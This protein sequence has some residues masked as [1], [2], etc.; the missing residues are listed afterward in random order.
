MCSCVSSQGCTYW[1]GE[2]K[3]MIDRGSANISLESLLVRKED[4][5]AEPTGLHWDP[6]EFGPQHSCFKRF[7]GLRK[8]MVSSC[9]SATSFRAA[10]V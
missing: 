3:K 5:W 4:L 7:L 6:Q 8:K 2:E 10:L 1:M 9:M